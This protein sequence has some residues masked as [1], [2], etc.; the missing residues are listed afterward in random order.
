VYHLR[1]IEQKSETVFG[2]VNLLTLRKGMIN[3]IATNNWYTEGTWGDALNNLAKLISKTINLFF[4]ESCLSIA[5][6][7]LSSRHR[8][9]HS[10][11]NCM[12]YISIFITAGEKDKFI[13]VQ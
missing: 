4:I 13:P 2:W 1:V 10:P 3:K 7:S 8:D 6:T 5:H 9:I 11:S 12:G